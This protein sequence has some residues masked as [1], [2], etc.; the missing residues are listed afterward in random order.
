MA[1]GNDDQILASRL[2][3]CIEFRCERFLRERS[4]PIRPS[5]IICGNAV[6]D[7]HWAGIRLAFR[8]L[9]GR[10]FDAMVARLAATIGAA[11][12]VPAE[13]ADVQIRDAYAEF[14]R[15]KAAGSIKPAPN[16]CQNSA[17]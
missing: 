9:F 10:E 11:D 6:L 3:T 14:F 1:V 15:R 2:A 7:E 8:P 12:G 17:I 5:S 4:D 13:L 16:L